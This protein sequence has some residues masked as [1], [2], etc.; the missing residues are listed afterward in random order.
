M[1]NEVR[2]SDPSGK[3]KEVLSSEKLSKDYWRKVNCSQ[4][5]CTPM[6]F[7]KEKRFNKKKLLDEFDYFL[8]GSFGMYEFED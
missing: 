7:G 2:V 4:I 8:D 5:S 3:V 6:R 1:L